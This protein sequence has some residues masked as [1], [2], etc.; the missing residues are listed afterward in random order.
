MIGFAVEGDAVPKRKRLGLGG[1][2]ENG[3][4][5]IFHCGVQPCAVFGSLAN[6]ASMTKLLIKQAFY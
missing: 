1:E 2:L 4:S 6:H 5:W 3:H